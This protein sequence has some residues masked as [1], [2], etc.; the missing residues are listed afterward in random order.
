[1][2]LDE[3]EFLRRLVEIPS[4]SGNENELARFLVNYF[5][6]NKINA[7]ID[8][9]G[10]VI[11]SV[12]SGNR[13]LV[14]TSH[15]DTVPG[16]INVRIEDGNLYGRG[17]VDAKS[18]LA[19]FGWLMKE[20]TNN[21]NLRIVFI[22]V[23]DEER[24]SI[25][26]RNVLDR[27]SPDFVINGEP[28]G[29]NGITIGYRGCV[30]FD[31]SIQVDERHSSMQESA[32]LI[33][34]EFVNE[35]R[36]YIGNTEP[37]FNSANIE[38]PSINGNT[39]QATMRLMIRIPNGFDVEGFRSFVEENKRMINI[40][41]LETLSP[42]LVEKNN[43]LVRGLISAIREEGGVPVFKKKTGTS[44]MNLF[45]NWGCPIVS[46]AAGDSSLDHT[47]NE[48]INLVEF[49]KSVNVLRHLIEKLNNINT[50]SNE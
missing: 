30:K 37:S 31:C 20:F 45:V 5:N 36:N 48:H 32:F 38:V 13:T 17:S 29:W 3:V 19:S 43:E 6:D 46:Y 4:V 25:G 44:D 2:F 42:V 8:D 7:E 12:G 33:L 14:L 28:S 18:G 9:V 24:E 50:H 10:N 27:F 39:Y 21:Q 15:L 1:M 40:R 41:W 22:G 49:K 16:E 26:A 23:V 34:N 35:I 47:P 11:A